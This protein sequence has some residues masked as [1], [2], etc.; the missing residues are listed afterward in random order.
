MHDGQRIYSLEAETGS[1]LC[2][3]NTQLFA[4]LGA[5]GIDPEETLCG[6]YRESIGGKTVSVTVWRLKERSKCG[7]YDTA[8]MIRAWNDPHFARTNPEHPL[9]YLRAGFGNYDEARR[10]IRERGPIA[11]KRRGKRVALITRDTKPEH[12]ER[13][14]AGLNAPE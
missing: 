10:F 5:L 2:T 1:A 11:I 6:E 8:E 14:L 9:A 13:I 12:R 7:R 3:R 4:A